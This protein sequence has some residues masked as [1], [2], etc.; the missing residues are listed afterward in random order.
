MLLLQRRERFEDWKPTNAHEKE[1]REKGAITSVLDTFFGAPSEDRDP[2]LP[3]GLDVGDQRE[4]LRYLVVEMERMKR[5]QAAARAGH[6][7]QVT[8]VQTNPEAHCRI[9][10]G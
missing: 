8:E 7:D 5:A 6:A 9:A 10:Q 1:K 2:D 4:V 3:E